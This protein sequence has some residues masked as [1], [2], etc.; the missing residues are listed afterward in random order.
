M[1]TKKLNLSVYDNQISDMD[2]KFHTKK[3]DVRNR[4][5]GSDTSDENIEYED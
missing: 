5:I 3:L 2:K 4:F 1:I